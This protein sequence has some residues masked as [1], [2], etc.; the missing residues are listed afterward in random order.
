LFSWVVKVWVSIRSLAENFVVS[1]EAVVV[2]VVV[3]V[4]EGATRTM[5]SVLG[6]VD[7]AGNSRTVI[8]SSSSISTWCRGGEPGGE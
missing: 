7:K 3:E 5:S 8:S 4:E 6:E 2:E 1:E